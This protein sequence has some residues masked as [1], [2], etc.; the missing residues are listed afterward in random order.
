MGAALAAVVRVAKIRYTAPFV[1]AGHR[2]SRP[3]GVVAGPYGVRG[4][5]VTGRFAPRLWDTGTKERG[6][7]E[8]E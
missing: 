1:V 6:A 3:E 5:G 4:D 2:R 8:G 7:G